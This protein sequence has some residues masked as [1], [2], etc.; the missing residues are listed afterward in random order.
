[1]TE[2]TPLHILHV[3]P[4][5]WPAVAYGGPI[6]STKA[7]TDGIANR[8]GFVIEV[9]T[10]DTADPNSAARLELPENPL[11]LPAGYKVRYCRKLAGRSISF[12]MLWRLVSAVRRADV[13][14]LT[15]PYNFPVIPTLI[16]CRLTGTPLVWSPRGGFQA[17]EQWAGSPKRRVKKVFE[18]L[19]AALA[20][21]RMVLHAT[22]TMEAET[23]SRNFPGVDCA[24][25]PN[26]IDIPETLPSRTWRPGGHLRL[27]FLSRLHP[28]KGLDILLPT[29]AALPSHVTLDIYGAGESAY[30]A[31]LKSQI[32]RQGLER[33]VRFH[34]P[35]SGA[36]KTAAF[37]N[38]DLF[39]LPTHSEN[40]GI[41]VAESLAHG[42]PVVTTVNA[43]WERIESEGCGCWTEATPEALAEAI[44]YLD[45]ADL[46]T[47]GA[48]GRNWMKRDF[49]VAGMIQKCTDLY[50]DLTGAPSSTGV[51]Q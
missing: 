7:I 49:S 34:G 6:F 42:T 40:F 33:R 22:A 38:C 2:R 5:F 8:S 51:S 47:M 4:S 45:G 16:A 15:G 50:R 29:L 9:L 30:L 37:T 36:A 31:E 20:P 11:T 3:S 41:V 26:A 28:K 46:A 39:V 17:T 19:C 18:K 25:I 24:L 14:H 13:V 27:A 1:M 12:E 48:R 43:P 44:C 35:V 23:S 21:S 10:T 32:E